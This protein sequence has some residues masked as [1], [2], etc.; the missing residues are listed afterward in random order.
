M[1]AER[2]AVAVAVSTALKHSDASRVGRTR[3]LTQGSVT[4]FA[5]SMG[6]IAA[7]PAQDQAAARDDSL[8]EITVTGSRIV[9]KDFEAVSPIVTVGTEQFEQSS[10]IA[11][12]ANLNKLPQFTPAVTQFVTQD[13]QNTATNTVGASTRQPSRPRSQSQPGAARR[14]PRHAGQRLAWSWTSTRSRLRRSSAWRSSPAARPRPTAR[15]PSAASSTSSSRR[16][17]RASSS[18]RSTAPP[19]WV[20]ARSSGSPASSAPTSPTAAA[21]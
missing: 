8:E 10:T 18:T 20:M 12:E 16:T 13:V 15:M 7:A 14:A 21:T 9:R 19:S 17:S 3:I 1:T 2:D 4:A 5:L 6:L 11:L